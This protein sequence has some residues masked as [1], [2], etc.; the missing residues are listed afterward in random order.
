MKIA[1][2]VEADRAFDELT[3]RFSRVSRQVTEQLAQ[4]QTQFNATSAEVRNHAQRAAAELAAEQAR[5]RKQIEALPLTTREGSEALRKALS[6][7]VRALEELSNLTAREAARRDVMPPTEPIPGGALTPI[8]SS[9]EPPRQRSLSSLTSTLANELGQ[10]QRKSGQTSSIFTE[11]AEQDGSADSRES[12]SLGDLLARASRDEDS[13]S[14]QPPP[15]PP[16]RSTI[17]VDVLARA[18]DQ[19]TAS[20]IWS[21]FRAGQRGIMVRSIYTAEGRAAFDEVSSRYRSDPSF[22]EMVDRYLDDFEQSLRDT[23]HQTGDARLLANRL[24]SDTGRVYLFLAHA[25]GRLS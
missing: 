1:A 15:P 8:A 10:R 9:D 21:R 22:R 14:H 20:A 24:V 13:A 16:S 18:L 19:A 2:N 6:D 4:L 7:Q 12:W 5:L 3:A 17:D 23:E 25:S 11:M